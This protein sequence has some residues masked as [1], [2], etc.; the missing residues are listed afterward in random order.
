MK[1]WLA[2]ILISSF[3]LFPTTVEAEEK[4][5]TGPGHIEFTGDYPVDLRD[6]EEPEQPVDPVD[7]VT[8]VGK[9]LRLEFVPK[10]DFG[11]N[12]IKDTLQT[13]DAK[14]Q[15]FNSETPARANYVQLSDWR[16][17][18]KGWQLQ[19]KQ[20]EQFTAV[21]DPTKVLEGAE[22]GFSNTTISSWNVKDPAL[23]PEVEN[24][25]TRI[26]PGEPTK[27]ATAKPGTGGGTWMISFGKNE[28]ETS[29]LYDS[30]D[31]TGNFVRNSGVQLAVPGMSAKDAVAYETTLTWSL[32]DTY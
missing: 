19:V 5:Q 20:E 31:P 21:S 27:V 1:Q 13:Y 2:L 10:L 25:A 24:A 11:L 4:S 9:M 3:V 22:L 28:G 15:L 7:P 8:P 6:P 14:A 23:F 17:G 30:S 32:L 12:P 26:L 18:H 16:A 29:T